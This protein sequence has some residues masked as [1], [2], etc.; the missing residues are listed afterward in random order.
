MPRKKIAKHIYKSNLLFN[1]LLIHPR[2]Y[3]VMGDGGWLEPISSSGKVA[4]PM[5]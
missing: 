2:G 1:F 4:S 3:K 5:H